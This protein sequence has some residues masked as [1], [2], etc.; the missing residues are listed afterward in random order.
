MKIR[1]SAPAKKYTQDFGI[2]FPIHS[3]ID[4]GHTKLVMNKA[5]YFKLN[6]IQCVVKHWVELKYSSIV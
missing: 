5:L 4:V 1:N 6:N 2:R 3:E